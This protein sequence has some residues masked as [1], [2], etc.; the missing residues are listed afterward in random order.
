MSLPSISI[1][2]PSFNQGAFIGATI[3]SV[4]N[5]DYPG[6]EYLVVDGGS[7]DSTL[8]VLS[9]Y[10]DR[11]YWI[12]E[13]DTGQSNAI[14]KGWRRTNGEIVSWLNSDDVLY[15]GA[16]EAVGSYFSNHPDIDLLYGD[17]DFLDEA[18]G[19][20]E[21]YPAEAHDFHKLVV[22]T[23]NYIPQPATFMRRK[24]LQQVGYL[25]EELQYVMDLDY[26]LRAGIHHEFTYLPERLAGLRIH[27]EAKSVA[28][29]D[30]NAIALETIYE[31]F[32]KL[33]DL[34]AEILALKP[35]A[36]RAVHDRA[37]DCMFWAGN[38]S[39][40][41]HYA[42]QSWVQAPLRMNGMWVYIGLGSL[43]RRLAE[44]RMAN[45][46]LMSSSEKPSDDLVGKTA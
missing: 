10:G 41:R 31:K 9:S 14:N 12:S 27:G 24:L 30:K 16:L 17:C 2:T 8:D 26:W 15:P 43:G 19:I 40:A 25:D 23:V 5:Q 28:G 38:I 42:W 45:P 11:L 33:S 18:G 39:A 13:P 44:R 35:R 29:L 4:L 21:R 3:D 7:K 36:M 6:L 22:T 20:I 37:A 1:I 32:F 34:P 46:Y